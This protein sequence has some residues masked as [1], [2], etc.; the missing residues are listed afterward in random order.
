MVRL[1]TRFKLLVAAIGMAFAFFVIGTSARAANIPVTTLAG[2]DSLGSL[3]AAMDT[4]NASPAVKDTITFDPGLAGQISLFAD[5]PVLTGPVEITAPGSSKVII[6][7]KDGSTFHRMFETSHD[8]KLTGLDLER[9]SNLNG[10]AISSTGSNLVLKDILVGNSHS[11]TGKGGAIHVDGGTLSIESSAIFGN[12]A[13][14][15]AGLW[16]RGATSTSISNTQIFGNNAYFFFAPGP[17]PVPNVGGG[18]LI[19]DSGSLEIEESVIRENTANSGGFAFSIDNVQNVTISDTFVTNNSIAYFD[20]P[21]G[22]DSFGTA[23]IIADNTTIT[24][25]Q[26]TDNY[27]PGALGGLQVIGP[28]TISRCLIA[29]N[30][31]NSLFTG[32]TLGEMPR[33]TVP[34]PNNVTATVSNTTITAN[35][36]TTLGSGLISTNSRL[37]LDSS[38]ISGNSLLLPALP[39]ANSSGVLQMSGT[40]TLTNSI[41]SG[42]GVSD[43]S[44]FSAY[45]G[46][47][48][49]SYNLIGTVTGGP[50]KDLV[51]GSNIISNDPELGPLDYHSDGKTQTMEP[52][53][54]SPVVD[55]GLS[56]LTTDQN[57]L[58]RPVAFG[59]IPKPPGGNRADIGA[60]EVQTQNAP[61]SKFTIGKVKPN[62]K[63]G[64]ATV[65]VTVPWSG[66]VQLRGSKT[67]KP[68]SKS[69]EQAATITLTV[70]ARGKAAK[71]LKKK[72]KAKVKANITFTTAGIKPLTKPKTVKLFKKKTKKKAK[73]N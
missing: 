4:A 73:K 6:E 27:S 36:G 23:R 16:I 38:T 54:D 55:Q 61:A 41:V 29:S 33:E 5:L 34:P 18:I 60:V 49:G 64:T 14:E 63:K 37:N 17:N 58:P 28:V 67:V 40:A 42:N 22:F 35:K 48:E 53:R 32:L 51:P 12:F 2:D 8:L 30:E 11:Y 44:G 56:S 10:G 70:K 31:S 43:I 66:K 52:A 26:F 39:E 62:R 9:G 19:E 15:G 3:H 65:K 72:G 71:A 68:F 45:D 50:F 69:T 46:Y 21:E 1:G 57:G 7:G 24:D 20:Y 13:P 59:W 47:V 25:S